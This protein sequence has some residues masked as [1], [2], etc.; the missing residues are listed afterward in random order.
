VRG[1]IVARHALPEGIFP[2]DVARD[3]RTGDLYVS[4]SE[5]DAI[6][7]FHEGAAEIWLS[8]PGIGDPNGL[9]VQG[10]LLYVCNNRDRTLKSV[11][12]A[13]RALTPVVRFYDGILDGLQSDGHGNLL[14][15]I[16][17]GRLYRVT[18]QG[19][20]V[21]LLD[22]TNQGT[23]VADFLFLPDEGLLVVPTFGGNNVA[24]YRWQ[25]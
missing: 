12:L 23:N 18:P 1:E 22:T 17:E 20:A 4:D 24:A 19:E 14:M 6:Y 25:G 21:K 3:P 10:D 2:N 16:W 8:G 11:R 7:R 13:D 9:L 15:S 5:R